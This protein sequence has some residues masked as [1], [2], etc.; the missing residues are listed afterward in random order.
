MA[1]ASA[2]WSD[3]FIGLRA[4]RPALAVRRGEQAL[5]PASLGT[6][7]KSTAVDRN[8]QLAVKQG[9]SQTERGDHSSL[10]ALSLASQWMTNK[11]EKPYGPPPRVNANP[12][13]VLLDRGRLDLL[14]KPRPI[15]FH[16]R[17]MGLVGGTAYGV[18]DNDSPEP[19]VDRTEHVA[20]RNVGFPAVITSVSISDPS[21]MHR[22]AF[23]PG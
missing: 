2:K 6:G 9:S 18:R 1:T 21:A 5:T 13:R 16:Q 20:T 14:A 19:P 8:S 10:E 22:A 11:T 15:E 17:I 23:C 7:G 12:P 4:S 3:F